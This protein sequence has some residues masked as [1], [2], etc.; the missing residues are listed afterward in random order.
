MKERIKIL[1]K[2]F[3]LSQT[4]FGDKIGLGQT[5][6]AAIENGRSNASKSAIQAICAAFNVN[7]QWL[8]SGE[9]EML[10]SNPADTEDGSVADSIAG[11]IPFSAE[12][13]HKMWLDEMKDRRAERE[14][15]RKLSDAL[16]DLAKSQS[17]YMKSLANFVA[18]QTKI[19]SGQ[20]A[21][22][23]KPAKATV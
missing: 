18:E 2:H 5:G 16:I 21:K 11:K 19:L 6:V 3:D 20:T 4:D 1:R 10:I 7:K 12:Q 17:E 22:P 13:L 9:G 23:S 15:N 8:L 14:D